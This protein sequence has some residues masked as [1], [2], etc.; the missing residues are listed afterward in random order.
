MQLDRVGCFKYEAV[1]GANA[2]ALPDHVDEETK[3]LR[4]ELLM[5]AQQRISRVRLAQKVGS[6]QQVLIDE[7]DESGIGI[8]RTQGDAPE[9]DG[10]VHTDSEKALKEGEVVA[11]QI[12]KSDEYD[13]WGKVNSL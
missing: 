3:D 2:N 4:Y 1:D 9:I 10:I 11:V 12:T 13:L 5:A 7:V 8:G 6:V